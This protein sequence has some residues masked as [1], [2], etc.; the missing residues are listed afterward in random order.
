MNPLRRLAALL[1]LRSERVALMASLVMGLALA[2][3]RLLGVHGAESALALGLVLPPFAGAAGAAAFARRERAAEGLQGAARA[4]VLTWL[5]AVVLL[6]LN[7]LRVRQCTPGTGFAFMVL[8]PGFG[9]L[10][11]AF[12]GAFFAAALPR[13]RLALV[14]GALAPFAGLATALHD[15]WATPAIFVFQHF[16]GW[17]PGTLYDEGLAIPGTLLTFRGITLLYG[18][19]AAAGA[20]ALRGGRPGWGA[21]AMLCVALAGRLDASGPELGHASSVGAIDEALGRVERGDE[22]VVHLP[23]ELRP[24]QRA[25]LVE[26]CDFRVR[27]AEALLGVDQREPVHAFFYRSPEEKRRWMGAATT[28]IAKPWRGEVHLQLRGWPHPVLAHEIVHVVAGEAAHGPFR[29]AG[30]WWPNPGFVEGIAVA[31]EWP[32]RDGMNPH[33]QARTLLESERLPPLRRLLSLG[34]LGES[35]RVAYASAGSFVR[36]LGDTR[37]W[38]AV[39]QAHDDGDV[40]G[41]GLELSALESEWRAFV[42][43][44]PLPPGA[45]ELAELRFHRPSIFARTCPHLV[46]RLRGALQGDLRAGDDTAALATCEEILAIEPADLFALRTE[47]AALARAGRLDAAEAKLEALTAGAPLAL[48]TQAREAVADALWVAGRYDDARARYEALLAEPQ[49]EDAARNREVKVLGTRDPDA[50]DAIRDLLVGPGG[51][52]EGAPLPLHHAWRIAEARPDGL[53]PYLLA[54]QLWVA[55]R[56]D[57]ARSELAEAQRRGLPSERLRREALR[58]AGV[59]SFAA[60][61]YAASRASFEAAREDPALRRQAEEWLA[62]LDDA[63]FGDASAGD[64]GAGDDG[65]GDDGATQNGPPQG[66]GP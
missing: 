12:V 50:G 45:R 14:L 21:L 41:A 61:D 38:E 1:P 59:L 8:G 64:D 17:F 29:V 23:R 26:D 54:R 6:A 34:F 18:V 24:D 40:R 42:A 63:R 30:G 32:E 57:L 60:G 44:V 39:R 31:I 46:A 19:A 22:C 36:W 27:R 13:K 9:V 62:R 20:A 66:D 58:L 48:V 35:S 53:G 4:A 15:F 5:P 3:S 56:L 43:E 25:R 28:Y 55:G 2:S 47:V 51:R 52:Q 11:A 37:G 10:L 49:T 33:Q 7:Q 65:A 16:A